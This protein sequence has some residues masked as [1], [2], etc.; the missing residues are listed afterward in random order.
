MC[1]AFF[2][3][4]WLKQ[5]NSVLKDKWHT[6]VSECVCDLHSIPLHRGKGQHKKPRNQGTKEHTKPIRDQ[7]K[8]NGKGGEGGNIYMEYIYRE[9]I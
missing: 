6:C 5:R 1:L 8:I 7:I 2:L 3:A 9:Y 4:S